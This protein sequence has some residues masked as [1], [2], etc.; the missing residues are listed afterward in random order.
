MA[1]SLEFDRTKVLE[2]AM[3]LFWARGYAATS[4][5]DLLATM[6][7]ARSSFYASFGTKRKLFAECLELFG[8]RTLAMVE[9]DAKTLPATALPRAFFEA[10]VLDVSQRTSKQGCLLVNTVLELADVDLELNQLATQKLSSIEN[11]FMVAFEQA[12]HSGNLEKIH[13]PEE[14]ASLVMT[15]NFGLRV[16]SRQQLSQQA[17]KPII[18]NSLS[19]LGLAE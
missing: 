11:T 10:T 15:V 6:G 13:S 1:R 5:P 2:A 14:L 17:M 18:E 4:L 19:L 7:I 12:Q 9:H 16:R 3:K 8:D